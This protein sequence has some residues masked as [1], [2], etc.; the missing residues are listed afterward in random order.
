LWGR[1]GKLSGGAKKEEMSISFGQEHNHAGFEYFI[2]GMTKAA[3]EEFQLAVQL[4]ANF[5]TG[6]NNLAIALL[7]EGRIMEA[8]I[9][10]EEVLQNEP[11]SLILHNNLGVVYSLLGESERG[12]K[13][14]EIVQAQDAELPVLSLNLGDIYYAEGKIEPALQ[15]YKKIGK[16][17]MLSDISEQ[18]LLY[19]TPE[20]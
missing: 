19:K 17:D 3:L 15:L 12:R 9:K 13:E 4:D 8:K 20:T 18:R 6:I 14:L 10:L 5:T 16:Y 1:E 11:H 7:K 2:K